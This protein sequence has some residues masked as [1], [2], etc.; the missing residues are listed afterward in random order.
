MLVSLDGFL[1][2]RFLAG[3][4]ALDI[5]RNDV[6]S[7]VVYTCLGSHRMEDG[8]MELGD[9]PCITRRVKIQQL[10]DWHGRTDVT[11]VRAGLIK[12]NDVANRPVSGAESHDVKFDL[13]CY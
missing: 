7:L 2:S 12:I 1:R 11:T 8:R 4:T 10:C 5:Q 6:Y 3:G 9:S 13:A